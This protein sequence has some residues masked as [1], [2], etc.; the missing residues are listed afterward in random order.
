MM[1]SIST[2][3]QL[4]LS[5]SCSTL[6]FKYCQFR[7]SLE[8]EWQFK[9]THLLSGA[10][11]IHYIWLHVWPTCCTPSGRNRH[12]HYPPSSQTY[13]GQSSQGSWRHD[14]CSLKCTRYEWTGFNSV[15]NTSWDPGQVDTNS[16]CK[17]VSGHF[18][19]KRMTNSICTDEYGDK[20][21]LFGLFFRV[22]H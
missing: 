15:W 1:M 22:L 21:S 8:E 7:F 11:W 18:D 16:S 12:V 4:Q 19:L 3:F 10:Y 2:S 17:T 5:L 20:V 6:E 9:A 14:R 13:D